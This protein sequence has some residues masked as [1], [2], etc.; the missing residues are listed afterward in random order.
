MTISTAEIKDM[1][2]MVKLINSAYR[3]EES[4]QGWTTE[5]EMV[6][7][8]LR[9]NEE[10]M[11]ELMQTADTVFLKYCNNEKTIEGAVFL[12]KRDGKLYLG[13]LSVLPHLQT[14]GIGKRLMSA[15]EKY[16]RDQNCLAVFMR[17]IS[18]RKE[19]IA[20][21]EKQGYNKTGEIQPFTDGVFGTAKYPI[22]FIMLQ[23]NL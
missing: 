20:W 23:K 16:A 10:H 11:K 18:M 6:A 21:Y 1:P 9:I 3:G 19:L 14:K 7:G 13:M 4:R 8:D 17:V 22:E 5:A 12:Q 2:E 15:S